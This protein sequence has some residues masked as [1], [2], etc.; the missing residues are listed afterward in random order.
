MIVFDRH[1]WKKLFSVS[2]FYVRTIKDS[3]EVVSSMAPLNRSKLLQEGNFGGVPIPF[4]LLQ[5][6]PDCWFSP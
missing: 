3:L 4:C 2:K 1:P 5:L 6:L